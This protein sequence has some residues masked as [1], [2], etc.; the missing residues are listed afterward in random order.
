[1]ERRRSSA[2]PWFYLP[3]FVV[4]A[5]PPISIALLVLAAIGV[6]QKS[7]HLITWLFVAFVVGHSLVAHKELRFLFPMA[8]PFLWLVLAGWD[9]W[10]AR[11][12]AA[13]AIGIGWRL[14]IG[15]NGLALAWVCTRPA[16]QLLPAWRFLY[17]EGRN[18]YVVLYA[19]QRSP[20]DMDRLKPHFYRSEN[21]EVRVVPSFIAL[22]AGDSLTPRGGDFLLQRH[23][24]PDP[25]LA[26]Y[27]F[28]RVFRAF[29][30]WLLRFNVADWESRTEI[31]SIYRITRPP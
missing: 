19:E 22:G 8:V 15:I 1:M 9:Q 23:L 3:A 2:P 11:H 24:A 29:P 18:R 17:G 21:V 25:A 5:L 4:A 30:D 12:P 10:R 20:Y 31:W 28:E 6:R 13:T 26:G 27:Q 7:R 14:C 16:Q